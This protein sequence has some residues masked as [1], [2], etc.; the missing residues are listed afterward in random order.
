MRG[1]NLHEVHGCAVAQTIEG[2]RLVA[3]FLI[4]NDGP[5]QALENVTA[6]RF[7]DVEHAH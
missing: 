3:G 6:A 1:S 7:F 4:R 5:M 2:A